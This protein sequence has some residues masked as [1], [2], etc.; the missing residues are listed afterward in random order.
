MGKGEGSSARA[1]KSEQVISR[2]QVIRTIRVPRRARCLRCVPPARRVASRCT[3]P[4]LPLAA[5]RDSFERERN[6]EGERRVA[7]AGCKCIHRTTEWNET[8]ATGY[9]IGREAELCVARRYIRGRQSISPRESIVERATPCRSV[10]GSFRR[11]DATR[12]ARSPDTDYFSRTRRSRRVES[13][14][15]S[16]PDSRRARSSSL[17]L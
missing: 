16:T 7:V 4:C 1:V 17:T 10:D 11:R 9:G 5:Q 14:F 8:R 2:R 13:A 12:R 3:R 15:K 6:R